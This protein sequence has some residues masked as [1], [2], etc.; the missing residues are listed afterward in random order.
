MQRTVLH[1]LAV[2]LALT[3]SSSCAAEP[4]PITV[5]QHVLAAVRDTNKSMVDACTTH[6]P[7]LKAPFD[8]ATTNYELRISS[9]LDELLATDSFKSL[10][11][12]EA[13][14]AAIA[15]SATNAAF[16]RNVTL[17]LDDCNRI[18]RDLNSASDETLKGVLAQM[19]AAIKGMILSP[20]L[21]KQ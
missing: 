13:P 21:P 19:L 12:A 4:E 7:T 14:D 17:A 1:P 5:R 10:S 3:S 18:L 11:Q 2:V 16:L 20:K 15:S 8:V 9:V 6:H